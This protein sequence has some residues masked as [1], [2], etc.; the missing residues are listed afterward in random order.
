MAFPKI[1]PTGRHGF[2]DPTRPVNLNIGQYYLQRFWNHDARCRLNAQYVFF[3]NG[4]KGRR[5]AADA[6][7]T[8]MN[9]GQFTD[10]MTFFILQKIIL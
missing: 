8:S 7:F 5:E 6:A 2:V 1:F 3:A 9:T 4:Q 10:G